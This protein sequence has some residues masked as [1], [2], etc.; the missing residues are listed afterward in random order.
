[1]R[2]DSTEHLLEI[3][4]ITVKNLLKEQLYTEVISPSD[5]TNVPVDRQRTLRMFCRWDL[6]LNF[7]THKNGFL[8]GGDFFSSEKPPV[9][10]ISVKDHFEINLVPL[11]IG[12]TQSF[13]KKIVMFCF[14][15]RLSADAKVDQMAHK[16]KK[17][18]TLS[19]KKSSN[20]YVDVPLCKDD[21]ELMKERAQQNKLFVYIKIPEVPITVSFKSE[22]EKNKILDV[23]GFL[24]QVPTIE[25]H[26][27]TWTWLDF[28]MAVKSRTKDSLV[29][30]A[31][32]QK[33][34]MRSTHAKSEAAKNKRQ[35]ALNL[36]DDTEKAKLL[37]G[38]I[39]FPQGGA[40][41]KKWW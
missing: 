4:Y 14:P 26:N 16:D 32:K 29:S 36:Q 5:L 28:L 41:K 31:I 30:Q 38:D 40:R 3:G 34:S 6:L 35:N 7:D 17:K 11:S 33:L 25:Y 24:L 1:M 20:F 27:V 18:A 12:I 39:N 23:S 10:G 37:F 15:E 2:D 22:K 8:R 9:G 13:Y 21:V 19:S